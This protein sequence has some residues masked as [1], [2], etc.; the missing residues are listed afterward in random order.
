MLPLRKKNKKNGGHHTNFLSGVHT[1]PLASHIL[2]LIQCKTL[3]N[4]LD[5]IYINTHYL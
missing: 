1:L 2:G 4:V 5:V 3:W